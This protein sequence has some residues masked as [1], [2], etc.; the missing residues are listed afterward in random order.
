[1]GRGNLKAII[2][3]IQRFSIHDGPGIRTLIFMSGCS[4][5]CLWCSNPE[6]QSRAPKLVLT[7]EKCVRSDRCQQVCPTRA[8]SVHGSRLVLDRSLCN[9]CGEC[10]KTCYAGAWSILG[11]EVDVNYIVKEIEKDA[12]FYKNSGGGVTFG[13][14]EPTLWPDF[15]SAVSKECHRKGI[16]VAIETCGHVPWK[17]FE[18]I[19]DNVDLVMY[20]VK[21]MDP[22]MHEK[23]CGHPNELI[24]DNLKRISKRGNMEVIIRVPIIPGLNDSEDNISSTA[25]FVVSLNSNIKRVELLPYHKLGVKKHERLGRKYACEDVEVPSGEHMQ[26]IKRIMENCGLNVQIGG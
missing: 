22:K 5:T 18:E 24:L 16:S 20:D 19:L 17:N 2:F 4:L 14:G 10:V 12:L 15:I 6:S 21:H 13:G 7:A 3:D 26:S 8:I 23:L 9:L 11:R 1:M 25:R